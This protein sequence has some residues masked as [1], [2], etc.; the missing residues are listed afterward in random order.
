[1]FL[2]FP[3]VLEKCWK[4]QKQTSGPFR[5]SHWEYLDDLVNQASGVNSR[6]NES[7]K[8]LGERPPPQKNPPG[9]KMRGDYR[10]LV[11]ENLG[12]QRARDR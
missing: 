7:A 8:S 4:I 5:G 11:G 12:A 9:P 3:K 10:C 6:F 2:F 1:M